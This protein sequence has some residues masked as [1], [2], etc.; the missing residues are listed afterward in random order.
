[1][2]PYYICKG[3]GALSWIPVWEPHSPGG[4]GRGA[5]FPYGDFLKEPSLG[6]A[7]FP[8]GETEL[9]PA[10]S[11]PH[12]LSGGAAD[13]AAG[14]ECRYSG[15]CTFAYCQEEI[16]VWTLERKGAFSR[17]ALFEGSGEISL[18]VSWLLQEHL[19]LFMFLCEVL[20]FLGCPRE[21]HC[22]APYGLGEWS[23]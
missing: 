16:D 15:H 6:G 5:A 10:S 13:V 3:K 17:E 7:W 22:R 9:G 4:L 18:T 1:M 23:H 8:T 21:L 20:F 2:G 19:G 14:E 12:L 11:L